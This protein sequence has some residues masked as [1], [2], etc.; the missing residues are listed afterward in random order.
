MAS[1][2]DKEPTEEDLAKEEEDKVY[3]MLQTSASLL[4][5]GATH[6]NRMNQDFGASLDFEASFAIGDD[7]DD[8]FG[9][10]DA[11]DGKEEKK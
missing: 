10:D 8:D 9:N 4:D 1:N 7:D 5:T 6:K 2:D 3:D 11:S